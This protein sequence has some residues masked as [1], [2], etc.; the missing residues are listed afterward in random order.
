[1][2]IFRTIFIFF[3]ACLFFGCKKDSNTPQEI[4]VEDFYVIGVTSDKIILSY[5]LN[6]L[7]YLETGVTV[8][9]ENDQSELDRIN[10]LRVNDEFQLSVQNLQPNT[11]YIIQVFW[12]TVDGDK[13]ATKKYKLKTLS[14]ISDKYNFKVRDTAIVLNQLREFSIF[15]DGDNLNNLN[16]TNLKV[17]VNN[18]Q[19]TFGYPKLITGSK[20]ELELK[21]KLDASVGSVGSVVLSYENNEIFFQRV[22]LSQ[23]SSDDESYALFYKRELLPR[24]WASVYKNSLYYFLNN[25]VLLWNNA[26]ERLVEVGT[27]KMGRSDQIGSTT[28]GLEFGDQLF[29]IPEQI[30][31]LLDSKSRTYAMSPEVTSYAPKEDKWTSYSFKEYVYLE[32]HN[33]DNPQYFIQN[34]E[35]FLIYGLS[36]D[37]NSIPNAKFK[38]K[39]YLFHYNKSIKK[40]ES[41]P[42][43]QYALLNYRFISIENQLYAVGLAPVYD[44]GFELSKTFCVYKVNMQNFELVEIYR[45]GTKYNSL[46]FFPKHVIEYNGNILIGVDVNVFYL[47]ELKNNKLFPVKI[48]I[49]LSNG[50]LGNF[51]RYD[52]KLY[53]STSIGFIEGKNYEI[54]LNYGK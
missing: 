52:D 29:F 47:F 18:T 24:F 43:P 45:A 4:D 33:L 19:L 53:L 13:K 8:S 14:A 27:G 21:G 54:S 34:N 50:Y 28:P 42:V 3:V 23:S 41:V 20:Y 25:E 5:K 2:E 11:G 44:Q 51:F 1:M 22:S 48:P 9:K 39:I 30:S 36:D 46:F 35:L 31:Y 16:L 38:S 17:R 49:P 7:G 37:F 10:A 6:Q 40:F 32:F 15:I 12:K 26:E